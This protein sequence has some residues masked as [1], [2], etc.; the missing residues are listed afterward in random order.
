M[1]YFI[2]CLD[3]PHQCVFT[4]YSDLCSSCIQQVGTSC[5]R[6]HRLDLLAQC[7]GSHC[8]LGVDV[9]HL[10][11]ILWK[12]LRILG[13]RRRRRCYGCHHV[14]CTSSTP[15]LH[16]FS[17]FSSNGF[18]RIMYTVTLVFFCLRLYAHQSNSSSG[19]LG[20]AEKGG[21]THQMGVVQQQQQQQ[22][23]VVYPQSDSAPTPVQT[24][25]A[26]P[27]PQQWQQSPPPQGQY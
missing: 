22:Q 21:E 18:S 13:H 7:M 3:T 15:H 4:G 25:V 16:I 6:G 26:T 19:G 5:R 12:G 11:Q 24:Y 27:P 10:L 8:F 20:A 17:Q 2:V 14:V 1:F 9:V 23:Q